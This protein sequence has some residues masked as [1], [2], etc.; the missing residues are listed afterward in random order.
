M[1][2][3]LTT[4]ILININQAVINLHG[5]LLGVRD[6]A[7][8]ESSAQQPFGLRLNLSNDEAE[9]LTLAVAEGTKSS[10]DVSQVFNRKMISL[11]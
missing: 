6:L 4:D 1:P 5:G 9:A 2:E 7:A 10:G 8:L 3:P 11:P